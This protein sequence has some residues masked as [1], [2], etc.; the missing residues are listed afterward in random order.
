MEPDRIPPPCITSISGAAVTRRDL[1]VGV[2]PCWSVVGDRFNVGVVLK[3]LNPFS[4][5]FDRP[6]LFPIFS[7]KWRGCGT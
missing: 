5:F 7:D 2:L 3:D 4:Y 6:R 1:V